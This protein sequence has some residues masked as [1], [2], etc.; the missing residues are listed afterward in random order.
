MGGDEEKI[1]K[2]FKEN[3]EFEC[4]TGD[5]FFYHG[6]YYSFRKENFEELRFLEKK[7]DQNSFGWKKYFFIGKN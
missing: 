2:L 5:E 4:K 6:V 7:F 3:I 1:I